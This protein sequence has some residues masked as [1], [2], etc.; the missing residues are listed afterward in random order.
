[1]GNIEGGIGF[2]ANACDQIV[3]AG[4]YQF[5]LSFL[6][7]IYFHYF[8]RDICEY[9]SIMNYYLNSLEAVPT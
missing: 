8:I 1:V 9:F 3:E 5:G 7:F 2:F 6:R 4:S